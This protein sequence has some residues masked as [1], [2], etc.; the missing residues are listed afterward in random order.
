MQT[1]KLGER[2]K[3]KR[4]EAKLKQSDIAQILGVNPASIMRYESGER[5]PKA[6]DLQ[7]IA[8]ALNT[9]VG[10]LLGETDE[11]GKL[12]PNEESN[13]K[14]I[15]DVVMIPVI[16]SKNITACCGSGT[17]YAT[18][19]Q[20]EVESTFPVPSAFLAGYSWQGC[21]FVIIKSEGIS[22][23][24]VIHDGD[25][26][27]FAENCPIEQGDVAV[28]SLNDK[29]FIKG[30]RKLTR[31]S[32]VLRSYNWQVYPDIEVDFTQK[33]DSFCILGK[34]IKILSANDV[35]SIL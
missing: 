20:W 27:L 15:K 25:L 14:I 3:E 7:K 22:M 5:D 28:I 6:T 35:P 30:I 13:G 9:T 8:Q 17:A 2:L 21:N 18:D 16:S 19:V 34:V 10:Y 31:E 26:V 33:E 4:L 11:D 23:E 29:V 32:A 24:P 1:N 12:I